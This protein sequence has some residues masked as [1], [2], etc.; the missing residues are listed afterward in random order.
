MARFLYNAW[1]AASLTE[2]L[3]SQ[4]FVAR[5]I[6]DEPIVFFRDKSGT[7]VGLHD[8]CPHRFAPLHD[9]KLDKGTV[10]C[11]YHGLRFDASGQCV[12]NPH[13][14]GTIPDRAKVRVY[15]VIERSGVIW[16]W[17]GNPERADPDLLF[18][19]SPAVPSRPHAGFAGYLHTEANYELI[20]DNLM[21]LSH[22]DYVHVGSLN[23]GGALSRIRP[24]V[25]SVGNM[26]EAYWCYEAD[27]AQPVVRSAIP[28]PDARV[29]Q[30]FRMQW[31]APANL[32]LW[33][34]VRNVDQPQSTTSMA[35]TAHLLTPETST[36]SHY[37]FVLA[38]NW[39][40]ENAMLNGIMMQGVTAAFVEEDKPILQSVQK[41]MGGEDFWSLQPLILSCDPGPVHARR[42]LARL[43]GEETGR[44]AAD[45]DM[46]EST[47]PAVAT[48]ALVS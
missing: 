12:H 46:S 18:D 6:L 36:S 5:R 41:S 17:P 21:D 28:N 29:E 35:A 15:P 26:V 34:S 33:A 44:A 8:R 2:E 19:V 45:K 11:S 24:K 39:E 16:I 32:M 47:Q 43:I 30:T 25:T 4:N 13:G 14:D 1:Y 48:H 20:I 10:E 27:R 38:R 31:H 40:Q 9:G 42:T 37:F 7:P 23:T 3:G 22:A